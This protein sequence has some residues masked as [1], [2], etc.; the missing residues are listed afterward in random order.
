MEDKNEL[1]QT[2]ALLGAHTRGAGCPLSSESSTSLCAMQDTNI[3]EKP[4]LTCAKIQQWN[5]RRKEEC[6]FAEML[7]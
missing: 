5:G 3:S 1:V 2:A 6:V 4:F 7:L